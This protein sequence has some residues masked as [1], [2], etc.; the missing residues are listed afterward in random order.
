MFID[1]I[2]LKKQLVDVNIHR[3]KPYELMSEKQGKE[4]KINSELNTIEY[5]DKIQ[6]EITLFEKLLRSNEFARKETKE[7]I[8]DEDAY[9]NYIEEIITRDYF[10]ELHKQKQEQLLKV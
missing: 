9:I 4:I 7:T 5:S 1:K 10:P 2:K 3:S 8:I 6:T